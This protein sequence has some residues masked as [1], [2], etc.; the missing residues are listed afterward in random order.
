LEKDPF[1]KLLEQLAENENSQLGPSEL[2]FFLTSA[3]DEGEIA[4]GEEKVGNSV[5]M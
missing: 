1:L 3:V 2:D 4:S 5:E